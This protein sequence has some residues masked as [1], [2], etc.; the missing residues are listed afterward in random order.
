VRVAQ[1]LEKVFTE[2]IFDEPYD[3]KLGI[4]DKAQEVDFANLSPWKNFK[5]ALVFFGGLEGIEGLVEQEEHT[6]RKEGDTASLFDLYLN[7]CP[8]NGSRNIRTEEAVLVALGQIAPKLRQVGR[9]L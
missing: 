3:L 4:S 9:V 6:T 5:H 2:S 8:E 7:T 1:T